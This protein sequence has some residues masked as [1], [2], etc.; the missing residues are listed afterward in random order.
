M[1]NIILLEIMIFLLRL[2]NEYKFKFL[3]EPIATYRIHHHNLSF[4]RRD[5]HIKEFF[6][7]NKK[8]KKTD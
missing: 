7:W 6:Y 3:N 2:S 5:L 1:T 8:N 4:L